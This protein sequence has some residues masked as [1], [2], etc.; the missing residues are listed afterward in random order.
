MTRLIPSGGT[1]GALPAVSCFAGGLL[2]LGLVAGGGAR[3]AEFTLTPSQPTLDRLMY[4]FA[5]DGATRPTAYTFGSFDPRFD[6][7]DGQ[8]LL[9][10]DTA[11][12]VPTNRP[13]SRYLLKKVEVVVRLSS[14]R[15]FNYDPTHDVVWTYATNSASYVPDADLGRP[16]EL[17]GA[18]FRGGFTASTF[19]ENS[20]FGPLGPITGTNISIGTRN[21]Y[22]A[23]FDSTGALVDLSNNVGQTNVAFT[24]EIFEFRP[25]AIGRNETVVPGDLVPEGT[26]MTFE[27]DLSDPFVAGYLQGALSTGN[28]RMFLTSLHPAAQ[29]GFGGGGAYP[30]W[31]LRENLLGTPAMLRVEGTLVEDSDT[32]QDGLPDDWERFHFGGLD[33]GAASDPDG[34]GESNL[35]EWRT[36]YT[37]TSKSS[38]LVISAYQRKNGGAVF[39]F[40]TAPGRRYEIEESA[41]L[42]VWGPGFG[43]LTFP[44]IGIAE[45]IEE[46]PR[47]G[48]VEP[49]VRFHRVVSRE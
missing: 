45:W 23:V 18:G 27:V 30:Q 4:P 17:V 39:R 46:D 7:R 11:T 19:R 48:P 43:R 42:N 26:P 16:V 34:D 21:A 29:A 8:I 44:E 32:D 35:R 41:D 20:P 2:L 25:W 31:Y 47:M 28:L 3:A 6:T 40:P 33:Q 15:T 37:P 5:F 36:G 14:D 9:G 13:A 24:G 22:A 12:L 1:A 49:P 10:W 38:A